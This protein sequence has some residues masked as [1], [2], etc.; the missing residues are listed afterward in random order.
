MY[1]VSIGEFVKVKNPESKK[2]YRC[3]KRTKYTTDDPSRI[4][5]DAITI[6]RDAGKG[7][8]FSGMEEFGDTH[9]FWNDDHECP[10]DGPSD[11]CE[12]LELE[13]CREWI[14]K[15][16]REFGTGDESESLHLGLE[17]GFTEFIITGK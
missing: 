1:A 6:L 5:E 14:E 15:R 16:V 2:A 13:A 11:E 8:R 9:S 10:E 7:M 3:I 4:A 17:N 12:R